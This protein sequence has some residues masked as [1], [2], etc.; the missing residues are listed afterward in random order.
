MEISCHEFKR[1]TK[2]FLEAL[3]HTDS[4][5]INM[6]FYLYGSSFKDLL[7]LS[8][9]IFKNITKM[10][11]FLKYL[12]VQPS[13]VTIK[14]E[15]HYSNFWSTI[16]DAG[17][18]S[19]T[20]GAISD[21][22]TYCKNVA[23][24]RL[25]PDAIPEAYRPLLIKNA[26]AEIT[27]GDRTYRASSWLA[28]KG[29]NEII[30]MASDTDAVYD[31]LDKGHFIMFCEKT[32]VKDKLDR[33]VI[34]AD[35]YDVHTAHIFAMCKLQPSL[36]EL[37][38]NKC[39]AAHQDAEMLKLRM[40][41]KLYPIHK[42]EYLSVAEKIEK[43][44]SSNSTLILLSKLI[45]GTVAKTTI[46][47]IEFTRVSA[48]YERILIEHDELLNTLQKSLNFNSEFDIYSV[49]NIVGKEIQEIS[50]K[51]SRPAENEPRITIGE[52][53]IN[54]IP[55]RVEIS[56]TGCRY[57]NDVR[58]NKDELGVAVSRASC[59]HSPE[60]YKVF[61]ETIRALSIKHHDIIA[62]GLAVKIHSTITH[63]EYDNPEPGLNAPAI[64]F[65]IDKES[66]RVHLEISENRSVPVHLQKIIN[67]VNTLNERTN[68]KSS[69]KKDGPW[70]TTL[71][72]KNYK[73][74]AKEM[75][76][77]LISACTFEEEQ[78][79]EAGE[80]NKIRKVLINEED[81]QTLLAAA[82]DKKREAIARSK[83]FMAMAVR[84]TGAEMVEFLG[85]PAY[86]VAGKLR[87]YAV[88]IESAKVYDFD[89]KKYR[90]IVNHNH[91]QGAGYDDVATR[92]LALK[93]DSLTQEAIGTLQ[94]EAQPQYEPNTNTNMDEREVVSDFEVQAA[95][96]KAF[97]QV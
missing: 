40:L 4:A 81:V 5:Y 83:E 80:K 87:T 73:W 14:T 93:N 12:P 39:F 18:E 63:N 75:V 65:K 20:L 2:T 66:R 60:G 92:L 3:K 7:S 42:K 46:N 29:L 52:L 76:E 37:L 48:S 9:L 68:N 96:E 45:E 94:G 36:S 32:S 61:L 13:Q 67:R 53:K 43:D 86:K 47:E 97:T 50:D 6:P 89:T 17:I 19:K 8:R 55:I 10:Y 82:N 85:K 15:S 71:V 34:V 33:Y 21:S 35:R 58:V 88:V 56:H 41:K 23:S 38:K 77:I 70:H 26:P 11:H 22:Y 54:S 78:I 25:V 57:I 44:Y 31:Y 90:C 1:T 69:R 74:A 84:S 24:L 51:A 59:Y 62:N 30:H 49:C 72:T 79:N 28:P 91:Y 16:S 64:K 27:E 95:I